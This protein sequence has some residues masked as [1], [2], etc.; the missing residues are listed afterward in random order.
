[1]YSYGLG[2]GAPF[3]GTY[4]VSSP[5]G[6]RQKPN[7]RASSFHKG[8][9]FA[10][11]MGTVA[12]SALDGVVTRVS[13]DR[14]GYGQYVAICND[15]TGVCVQYAHMGNIDVKPGQRVSRG[16]P[17]GKTGNSG[18]STGPH[19]DYTV[20]KNG[21]LINMQ[22]KEFGSYHGSWLHAG[23]NKGSAIAQATA[24]AQA[25]NPQEVAFGYALPKDA[26]Q[27]KTT[28][29]QPTAVAIPD[30]TQFYSGFEK[31]AQDDMKL[32]QQLAP[33]FS[34]PVSVDGLFFKPQKI[35]WEGYYD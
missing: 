19:L 8:T 3:D 27:M 9:D 34:K 22:G 26:T 18:N 30:L 2:L 5:S 6:Y 29:A 17:I 15:A 7:Q 35:D 16:Q 24:P 4:R 33:E 20:T 1:M 13:N 28:T 21:R 23:K 14:N 25:P 31:Q 11:P 10:T 32:A 12:L